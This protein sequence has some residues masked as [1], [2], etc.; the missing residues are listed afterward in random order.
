MTFGDIRNIFCV[1]ILCICCW[2]NT[3]FKYWGKQL[4]STK[5][6]I[7]DSFKVILFLLFC[8]PL[9]VSYSYFFS[10]SMVPL[11]T[12]SFF[13]YPSLFLNHVYHLIALQQPVFCSIRDG[14]IIFK[15]IIINVIP[16]S[17][18]QHHTGTTL[19]R[20]EESKGRNKSI[21]S[22]STKTI[23]SVSSFFAVV[24]IS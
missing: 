16:S 23:S 22:T 12:F 8:L 10:C 6:F 7:L 15:H 11:F 13:C 21:W 19:G 24:C 3:C 1:F 17:K 18:T 4:I 2:A 9:T 20:K 14:Y 5:V